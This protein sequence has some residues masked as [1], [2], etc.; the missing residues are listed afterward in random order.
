MSYAKLSAALI[1][2]AIASYVSYEFC[3]SIAGNTPIWIPAGTGLL[4]ALYVLVK[5]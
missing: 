4:V 3:Q 2:G 1:M 5:L